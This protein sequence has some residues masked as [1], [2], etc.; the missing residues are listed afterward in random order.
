MAK[1]GG[2][3][4]ALMIVPFVNLIVPGYLAWVGLIT[5]EVRRGGS[6]TRPKS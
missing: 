3:W 2:W 1:N 5:T 6:P 4:G